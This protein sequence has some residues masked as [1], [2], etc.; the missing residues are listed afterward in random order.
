MGFLLLGTT[1]KTFFL[2]NFEGD[3]Y[4]LLEEG[5]MLGKSS[6]LSAVIVALSCRDEGDKCIQ[7]EVL[8]FYTG[9]CLTQTLRG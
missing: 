6:S 5:S 4:S 8:P 1:E 2:V 3:T 7:V 9:L